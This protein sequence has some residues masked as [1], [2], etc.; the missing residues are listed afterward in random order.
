MGPQNLR[1][2]GH[3]H[4]V[5]GALSDDGMQVLGDSVGVDLQTW[6]GTYHRG[7]PVSSW[8]QRAKVSRTRSG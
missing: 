3:L 5:F 1:D 4:T 2:C 6:G 8:T 7:S